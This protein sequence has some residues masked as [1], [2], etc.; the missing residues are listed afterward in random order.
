MPRPANS[1]SCASKAARISFSVGFRPIPRSAAHCSDLTI[2][3]CASAKETLPSLSASM[4][5]KY[6]SF[7]WAVYSRPSKRDFTVSKYCRTLSAGWFTAAR[8]LASTSAPR[9]SPCCRIA[10]SAFSTSAWLIPSFHSHRTNCSYLTL[11]L[12]P[13]SFAAAANSVFRCS[14]VRAGH[15][16]RKIT[17]SSSDWMAPLPSLSQLLN[18]SSTMSG[19]TVMPRSRCL[20]SAAACHTTLLLARCS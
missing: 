20:C 11:S 1:V 3:F 7:T 6:S 8:A 2:S 14:S 17:R 15:S 10:S 4:R 13:P 9:Q 12:P 5:L 19:V 16:L 18:A